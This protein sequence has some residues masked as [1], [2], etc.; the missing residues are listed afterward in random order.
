MLRLSTRL[1]RAQADDEHLALRDND[2]AGKQRKANRPFAVLR[3][4]VKV[5]EKYLIPTF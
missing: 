1:T 5:I 4:M 2:H 3:L